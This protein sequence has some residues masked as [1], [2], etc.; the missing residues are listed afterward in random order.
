MDEFYLGDVVRLKM[1]PKAIGARFDGCK[2][3][4]VTKV[5]FMEDYAYDV[6]VEGSEANRYKPYTNELIGKTNI[7]AGIFGDDMERIIKDEKENL[8]PDTEET[9]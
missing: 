4:V 6:Y 7:L 5:R 2:G 8:P 3:I 9:D 1:T